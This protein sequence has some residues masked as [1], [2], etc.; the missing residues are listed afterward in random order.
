MKIGNK[1]KIKNPKSRWF[2]YVGKVIELKDENVIVEVSN[3]K[4]GFVK[5]ELEKW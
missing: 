4:V 1:V 5:E 3:K 2:N